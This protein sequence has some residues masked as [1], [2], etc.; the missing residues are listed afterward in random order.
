LQ[1]AEDADLADT[2]ADAYMQTIN[3]NNASG[4]FDRY[5]RKP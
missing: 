3:W 2:A 4:L 1:I 5:S